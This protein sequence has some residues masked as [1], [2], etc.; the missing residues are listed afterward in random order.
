[1]FKS[2][3][4]KIIL[5]LLIVLSIVIMFSYQNLQSTIDIIKSEENAKSELV[6]KSILNAVKYSDVTYKFAEKRIN[7]QMKE[8]S[9]I[10]LDKYI[11]NPNVLDWDLNELK[12]KFNNYDVHVINSDLVIIMSTV[13]EDIGLDLKRFGIFS[14]LLRKRLAGNKFV[15]DRMDVAANTKEITKF[16]YMPT[17]DH[18]YLLELSTNV[19]EAF[20]ILEDLDII[21]VAKNLRDKHQSVDDILIYKLGKE[22]G[23][24]REINHVY[25]TDDKEA[26]E[27]KREI[28]KK[29]ILNNEIVVISEEHIAEGY[30]NIHKYI[31]YV[32]YE[33]NGDIDWWNSYVIEII[34]NDKSLQM[35]LFN[36]KSLFITNLIMTVLVFL[37]LL[38]IIRYL[39]NLS[40]RKKEKLNTV[41][42]TTSEGYFM[43]DK[44]FKI[45][46]ANESIAKMI[47]YPQQKLKDMKISEFIESEVFESIDTDQIQETD[48]VVHRNF[49]YE[50]KGNNKRSVPVILSTT[51]IYEKGKRKYIFS[52]ATDITKQ[53]KMEKQ[54]K[55]SYEKLSDMEKSRS[56]LLSNISHDLRTPITSMLGYL[57][58]IK[59][60][61]VTDSKDKEKYIERT[62]DKVLDLKKLIDD[63]FQLTKL[64]T[65]Q[66]DFNIEEISVDRLVSNVHGKY[67]LDAKNIGVELKLESPSNMKDCTVKVDTTRIEQVFGN[68][69][70]NAMRYTPSSGSI[71]LGWDKIGDN[72]VRFKVQDNGK[73][74]SKE[75]LP[76][77][78]ERFYKGSKSR[79]SFEGGNGIGLAISK[80][81]IEYHGGSIWI[82]SVKD[83]GSAFFFTLKI[84]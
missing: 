82:E 47:D 10:M 77:L 37:V 64:E 72:E 56:R 34:Y 84:K 57:E 74:I 11:M 28:G 63:L 29:V 43:L 40:E 60:G 81:I 16:S 49:E 48:K 73:G 31:P 24:M 50:L 8:Y 18:K 65:R 46:E 15:A 45:M 17:Q 19:N 79:N 3:V 55:E 1:M 42:N 33:E 58:L 22:G 66:I 27:K 69:I 78:F 35:D 13:K 62:Y 14:D 20:P 2:N 26:Q 51:T 75:D 39:I 4:N 59:N 7:D 12:N 36:Q 25:L 80:E 21:N 30:T 44:E 9:E 5:A 54:L 6:E 83:I 32:S 52:F 38:I 61:V 53:K 23:R 71:I 76:Y 68:L 70:T 41:I 67:E